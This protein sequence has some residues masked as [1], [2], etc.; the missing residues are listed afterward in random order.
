MERFRFTD[1]LYVANLATSRTFFPWAEKKEN[2]EIAV[3][4]VYV[5]VPSLQLLGQCS[6]F[7]EIWYGCYRAGDHC[8]AVF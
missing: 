6:E 5:R 1:K 4:S 8:S 3:L 2:V 7:H